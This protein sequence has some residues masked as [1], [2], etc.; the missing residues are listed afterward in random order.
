MAS[1]VKERTPSKGS[2][3]NIHGAKG[4]EWKVV[5]VVSVEDGVFP[6][7]NNP[8]ELQDER[9]P[10]Y[11]AATRAKDILLYYGKSTGS[12]PSNLN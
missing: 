1:S 2:P 9:R 6:M 5:F 11:V 3:C 8:E 12:R 7:R 10:M 4:L